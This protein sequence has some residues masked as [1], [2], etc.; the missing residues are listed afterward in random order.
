V[1]LTRSERSKE[2]EILVLRHEL[3]ILRRQVN[4]PPLERRDPAPAR[5]AQPRPASRV[6]RY[7]LDT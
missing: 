3:S 7:L 1:L 6:L 2:L 4:R 5:C